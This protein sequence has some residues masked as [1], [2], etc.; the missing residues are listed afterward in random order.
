MLRSV[1]PAFNTAGMTTVWDAFIPFRHGLRG[2]RQYQQDQNVANLAD[3]INKFRE[4]VQRDSGFA[5]AYYWLGL[6][7]QADSQIGAAADAFRKSI[8]LNPAFPASYLA[9]AI[10]LSNTKRDLPAIVVSEDDETSQANAARAIEARQRLHQFIALP[11]AAVSAQRDRAVAYTALCR[12]AHARMDE[13]M[14]QVYVAYFYCKRAQ[15]L[16]ARLDPSERSDAKSRE[17]EADIENELGITFEL[18]GGNWTEEST[19]PW[20]CNPFNPVADSIRAGEVQRINVFRG[21]Y[22]KTAIKHF[23]RAQDLYRENPIYL[24]NYASAVWELGNKVVMHAL[25]NDDRAHAFAASEYHD[26]ARTDVRFYLVALREWDEAIK[27][28]P[29]NVDALNGYA[30]TFW[31]W[32]LN[33]PAVNEDKDAPSPTVDMAIRAE[34]VARKAV[35][36]VSGRTTPYQQAMIRSTLGEVLLARSRPEEAIEQLQRAL[37]DAPQ[38]HSSD[39]LRWDLTVAFT[40]AAQNERTLN[41]SA[42]RIKTLLA[43]AAKQLDIIRKHEEK[44]DRPLFGQAPILLDPNLIYRV[45]M[46]EPDYLLEKRPETRVQYEIESTTYASGPLCEWNGVSVF[47]LD[48]LGR[49]MSV[50]KLRIHVWGGDIDQRIDAARDDTVLLTTEPHDSQQYYFVQAEDDRG[51]AASSVHTFQTYRNDEDGLCPQNHV[52]LVFR[53]RP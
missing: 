53:E 39:E 5:L 36:L 8:G 6:T 28:N 40:C 4:A 29:L 13:G 38:H 20:H 23:A 16:Y 45:C 22:T 49:Y 44:R 31:Q 17:V 42:D 33:N 41:P 52:K 48:N 12:D 2:W 50:P 19:A 11:T 32:R 51:T 46:R 18:A 7:L 34:Q 37:K 27:L 24:C 35:S 21:P 3:V 15:A 47:V 43:S 26:M 10:A 14:A 1:D 30:Y 25:Q 9:L